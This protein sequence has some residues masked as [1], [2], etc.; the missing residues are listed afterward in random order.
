MLVLVCLLATIKQ[1]SLLCVC[2]LLVVY[3][4]NFSSLL[5]LLISQKAIKI[6]R[7]VCQ[8]D[9]LEESRKV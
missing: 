6:Y 3:N 1:R 4:S 2:I 7:D 8:I 9:F 5:F